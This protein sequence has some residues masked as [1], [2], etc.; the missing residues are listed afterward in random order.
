M[1]WPGLVPLSAG[2]GRLSLPAASQGAL[3]LRGADRGGRAG[4]HETVVIVG[5]IDPACRYYHHNLHVPGSYAGR[6]G[7]EEVG[8]GVFLQHHQPGLPDTTPLGVIM[9]RSF[10]TGRLM[11]AASPPPYIIFWWTGS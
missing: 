4:Q 7:E 5:T 9:D 6:R 3:C 8:R 2:G 1:W 11:A 10:T